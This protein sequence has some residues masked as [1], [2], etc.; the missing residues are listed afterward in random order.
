M[1]ND[2]ISDTLSNAI[3]CRIEIFPKARCLWMILSVPPM[4]EFHCAFELLKQV[5]LQQPNI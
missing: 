1:Q 2:D 5:C 4:L 3:L